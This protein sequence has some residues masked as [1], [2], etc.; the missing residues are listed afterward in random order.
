M[1]WF[2][3]NLTE[4]V[5]IGEAIWTA[6]AMIGFGLSVW[7]AGIRFRTWRGLIHD[8]INGSTRLLALLRCLRVTMLGTVF[9]FFALIGIFS[10]S[11]PTHPAIDPNDPRDAIPTLMF[12]AIE[13]FLFMK[14][15]IEEILE[16][17]INGMRDM[18][19][20]AKNQATPSLS[21]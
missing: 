5:T 15:V 1:S 3:Y 16:N 19:D 13:L 14:V 8:G 7:F 21:D 2:F 10:M 17:A 20:A 18:R 11:L 4:T 12:I 6:I 9:V